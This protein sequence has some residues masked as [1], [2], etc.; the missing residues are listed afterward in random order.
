[1]ALPRQNYNDLEQYSRRECVEIT[2]IPSPVWG[3]ENVSDVVITMAELMD[4]EMCEDDIS[5]CHV[6][7]NN[8]GLLPRLSGKRSRRNFTNQDDVQMVE[9]QRISTMK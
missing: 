5:V 2:G 6:D 1:M 8:R 9:Q 7:P 4:V 3:E